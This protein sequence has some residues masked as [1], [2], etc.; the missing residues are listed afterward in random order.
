MTFAIWIRVELT[1]P[2][3]SIQQSFTPKP[4]PILYQLEY[5]QFVKT[6]MAHVIQL[7]KIF[8]QFKIGKKD[9][10]LLFSPPDYPPI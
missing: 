6:F 3:R 2:G 8:P 5:W 1:E 10:E 9:P 4:D 7:L